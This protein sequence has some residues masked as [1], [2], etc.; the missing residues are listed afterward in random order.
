MIVPTETLQMS[1]R[2]REAKTPIPSG[3]VSAETGP[4]SINPANSW[5]FGPGR[6]RRSS[7]YPAEERTAR[8][9][10]DRSAVESVDSSTR[11]RPS[12]LAR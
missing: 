1:A 3:I 5:L 2:D 8:W 7:P 4:P 12:A 9:F 6:G 10:I 11:L